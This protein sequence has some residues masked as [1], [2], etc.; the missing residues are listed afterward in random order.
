MLHIGAKKPQVKAKS[1]EFGGTYIV[2]ADRET[3]WQALNNVDVLAETIPGCRRIVWRNDRFLDLE[4]EVNLGVM[5]PKFAGELELS[6]VDSARSYTLFGRARGKFLGKA[7]GT[8][9]VSLSDARGDTILSFSAVG[10]ASER[11]LALGR[12]LIGKSVQR[13]IDH[14]FQRFADAIGV[15]IKPVES[16]PDP[17]LR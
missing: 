16:P 11:L 1:L 13:V 7:Q 10:G 6:D 14:F 15:E 2:S 8:A 17:S 9:K 5:H 12:P 4:V 3:V